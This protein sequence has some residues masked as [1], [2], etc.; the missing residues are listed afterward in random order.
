[1]T[2][3]TDPCAWPVPSPAD[4]AR[5]LTGISGDLCRGLPPKTGD[6]LTVLA[7]VHAADPDQPVPFTL[8]PKAHAL[9]DQPDGNQWACERC[10]AAYFSTPPDD[11]LCPA[12]RPEGRTRP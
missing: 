8:T 1:M 5:A 10:G 7:A 11:G 3:A 9:L 4:T 12:C 2:P 6:A